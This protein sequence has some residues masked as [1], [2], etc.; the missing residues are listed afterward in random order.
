MDDQKHFRKILLFYYRK[1]KNAAKAK[2]AFH[3]EQLLLITF[4]QIYL[5]IHVLLIV[6]VQI[7]K[8]H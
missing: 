1:G 7:R 4:S 6:K 5:L 3:R 2:I 8:L